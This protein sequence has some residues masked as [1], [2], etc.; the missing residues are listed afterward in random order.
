MLA[1][2]PF[3][4]SGHRSWRRDSK[5]PTFDQWE[6]C[7]NTVT[8][9]ILNSLSKD[10][11]E[12]SDLSQ[13]TPDITGYYTKMKKLREKLNILNAHAQCKCQRTCGAKANIQKAE[14]DT[15]LIQFLMGLNKKREMKPN[16]QLM[17]DSTAL[18]VNKPRNN[19]F[20]TSYG[21]QGNGPGGDSYTNCNQSS[22]TGNNGFRGTYSTNRPRPVCDYCKRPGHTRTGA[23]NFTVIHKT[24]SSIKKEEWLTMYLEIMVINM[25]V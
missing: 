15:R 10:Q 11:K 14:H 16:N 3:D 12:I 6:R 1:P 18:S 9:W 25:L 5:D 8:S 20:R 17:I 19:N 22:S 7:D 4:G 23:I 24:P 2:V 13:G 21:K